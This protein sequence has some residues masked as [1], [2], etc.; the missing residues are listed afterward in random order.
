MLSK[1]LIQFLFMGGL[2]S[3]PVVLPETK[4]KGNGGNGNLLLRLMPAGCCSQDCCSQCPDPVVGQCQPMPLV[5]APRHPQ[6]SPAQSLEG[7]CSFLRGPG[8][9]KAL[10]VPSRGSVSPVLR[11]FCNQ[12]PVAFKVKFPGGSRSL[13]QIP[14][15]G[16]RL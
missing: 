10:F 4:Y 5:E 6:V 13:C 15:L 3:L 14:R 7:H 11:K 8:A 1:S 16:N 2:Y 12:T 9:H